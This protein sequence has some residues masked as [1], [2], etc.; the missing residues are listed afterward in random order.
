[1]P[2]AAVAHDRD[3]PPAEQGRDGAR[4]GEPHPVAED[5]V[6]DVERRLRREGRAADVGRHVRVADL[7][8]ALA[9]DL[10][11]AKHR[12]L[13]AARAERRRALGDRLRQHGTDRLPMRVERVMPRVDRRRRLRRE[14]RL[15]EEAPEPADDEL[16][17][18]LAVRREHV[19]AVDLDVEL[20]VVGERSQLALDVVRHPLLDHEETPLAAH[21]RDQLLRD[22]RVDRVQHEERHRRAAARVGQ[23]EHVEAAERRVPEAALHHD[24]HVRLVAGEVLVEPVLDDVPARGG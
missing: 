16:R 2:E 7:R 18:V 1:M 10:H 22:E 17:D 13:G 5:R 20:R 23:A 21:E 9:E 14:P 6:A 11:R 19:L 15:D 12:P 4:R 8:L 3:D 24:A